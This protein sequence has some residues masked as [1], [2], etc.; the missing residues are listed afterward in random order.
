[1][2]NIIF[3]LVTTQLLA[4]SAYLQE[5]QSLSCIAGCSYSQCKIWIQLLLL[6]PAAALEQGPAQVCDSQT[7]ALRTSVHI[8]Q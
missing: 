4:S 2:H 7:A 3:L 8:T 6:R 1:M 5:G